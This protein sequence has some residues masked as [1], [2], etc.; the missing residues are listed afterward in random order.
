MPDLDLD[1]IK[2]SVDKAHQE[3]GEIAEQGVTRRWRMHIPAQPDRDS[4]LII[5]RA[6]TG[7]DALLA[8][9]KRLHS[10]AQAIRNLTRDTD[11]NDLDGDCELPVGEFQG[12]LVEHL[13]GGETP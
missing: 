1:A 11:G 12:A 10:F 6:L 3:I 9:V 4:D 5:S 7:V 8:E 2:A 13:D